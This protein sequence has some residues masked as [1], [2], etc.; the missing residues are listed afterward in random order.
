MP[1]EKKGFRLLKMERHRILPKF[2]IPLVGVEMPDVTLPE[3]PPKIPKLDRE[4]ID[5][6]RYALM[7]DIADIVPCVGD[8]GADLAFAELR[9]RL[10]PDEFSRFIE[11]NK[12]LPSSLAIIKTFAEKEKPK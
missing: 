11:N 9:K 7:D 12:I 3:F 2:K 5:I 8:V 6:L 1:E 4:Q 10:D